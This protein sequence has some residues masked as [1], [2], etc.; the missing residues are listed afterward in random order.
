MYKWNKGKALIFSQFWS[1]TKEKRDKRDRTAAKPAASRLASQ[2]L[3]LRSKNALRFEVSG[4]ANYFSPDETAALSG[5]CFFSGDKRDRTADLSGAYAG[6][7][8]PRQ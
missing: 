8:A 2:L 3:P 1:F 7:A 4:C 6:K 5:D